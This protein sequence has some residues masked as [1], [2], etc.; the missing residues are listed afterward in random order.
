MMTGEAT[1]IVF[2]SLVICCAQDSS[3]FGVSCVL[4]ILRSTFWCS[5]P[6]PPWLLRYR[7]AAAAPAGSCGAFAPAALIAVDVHTST[8]GA[9][10]ALAPTPGAEPNAANPP[11]AAAKVATAA[12]TL[13]LRI[14]VSCFTLSSSSVRHLR[15]PGA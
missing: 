8:V 1:A 11:S 10:A 6:S 3:P 5:F 15:S 14:D 12:T 2:G 4:Q 13:R 7:N 9:L